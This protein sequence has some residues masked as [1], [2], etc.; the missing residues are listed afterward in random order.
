[1]CVHNLIPSGG[2]VKQRLKTVVWSIAVAIGIVG[3]VS[4]CSSE[5]SHGEPEIVEAGQKIELTSP[6]GVNLSS[7]PCS[8]SSP[9]HN[10][11]KQVYVECTEI[12]GASKMLT[13][14]DPATFTC[15]SYG[16]AIEPNPGYAGEV[17]PAKV[18][19]STHSVNASLNGD[20]F[21]TSSANATNYTVTL[22]PNRPTREG[23]P[24]YFTCNVGAGTDWGQ[25]VIEIE[26]DGPEPVLD[27]IT[28][29]ATQNWVITQ[30]TRQVTATR[31]DQ[32]GYSQ[33]WSSLPSVTW[34]S[35]DNSKAT[36]NGS[37]LVTGVGRGTVNITATS[38][39]STG[40]K[41]ASITLTV[42]GCTLS[43]NPSGTYDILD[44]TSQNVDATQFCDSG[45]SVPTGNWIWTTSNPSNGV[46]VYGNNPTGTAGLLSAEGNATSL[47][48]VC[49][50]PATVANT[51][52]ACSPYITVRVLASAVSSSQS[53]TV[54]TPGINASGTLPYTVTN[55]GGASYTMTIGCTGTGPV[56]CTGVSPTSVTLAPNQSASV[57]AGWSTSTA[58]GNGEL[59]VTASGE[60]RV[61]VPFTV[62]GGTMSASIS[63]PSSIK[64]NVECQWGGT[65]NGG[66]APYTYNWRNKSF[67][68]IGTDP[69][70]NFTNA[71]TS[72][73]L[74]LDVTDAL[75][76]T[77]TASRPIT[78][79]SGAPNCAL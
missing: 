24:I 38:L 15:Q 12:W 36:V 1:M 74:Y 3:G 39:P 31:W 72:F 21:V 68:S 19:N 40:S 23:N 76:A 75:G 58:T 4:A 71:G 48:R 62:N 34:S 54:Q 43:T 29:S 8:Y 42:K 50:P 28:L 60:G 53:T 49:T 6:P 14:P 41:T 16:P 5:V 57:T 45:V 56:S 26:V 18:P 47:I 17:G 52:A 63:T 32:Y 70:L 10:S 51:A 79:S 27:H 66:T 64:P 44:G 11:G 35:S 13:W 22:T 69:W 78:V 67:G 9:W 61:G 55:T 65:V 37:G 2:S 25:D 73:T 77:V 46:K 7:F 20:P 59:V 33:Y 30:A